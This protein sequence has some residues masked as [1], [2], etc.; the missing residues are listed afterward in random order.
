MSVLTKISM[1][2]FEERFKPIKN[3]N[4]Q[5][6]ILFETY[7][8]DI[9][10]LKKQNAATLWT[11]LCEGEN[12]WISNGVHWVNRMNYIVTENKWTMDIEVDYG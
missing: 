4:F 10:F 6:T 11:L 9:Q 3:P 7:G 12:I 2:E 5:D 8:D 1:E